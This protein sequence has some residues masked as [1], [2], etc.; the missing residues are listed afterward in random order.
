MCS[1]GWPTRLRVGDKSP[2]YLPVGRV[3]LKPA[4]IAYETVGQN[5]LVVLP[6]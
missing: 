5:P 4:T 6:L 1:I 3:C 2:D